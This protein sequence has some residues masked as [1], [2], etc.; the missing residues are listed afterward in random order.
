MFRVICTGKN[1]C[2]GKKGEVKH[3]ADNHLVIALK[4]GW[5]TGDIKYIRNN[6]I[7]GIKQDI[8]E[9]KILAP[10]KK[11][12]VDKLL[13]MQK[14]ALE[15]IRQRLEWVEEKHKEIIRLLKQKQAVRK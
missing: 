3:L 10:I 1:E 5:I 6:N 8:K 2:Y 14:N 12:Y 7:Q 15:R 4:E 13:E 9:K 11:V